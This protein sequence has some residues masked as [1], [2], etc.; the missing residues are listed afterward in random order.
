MRITNPV[1]WIT[2][3]V[4]PHFDLVA[5]YPI[6]ALYRVRL[7]CAGLPSE[8]RNSSRANH[9]HALLCKS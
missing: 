3:S 6:T 2:K 1:I 8:R 5:V 4:A 9:P 7:R